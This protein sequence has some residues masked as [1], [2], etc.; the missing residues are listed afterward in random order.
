MLREIS[1]WSYPIPSLSSSVLSLSCHSSIWC[2]SF[3]FLPLVHIP[4]Y[5]V[6]LVHDSRYDSSLYEDFC[7]VV[8][9]VTHLLYKAP[10]PSFFVILNV[11][12]F[13]TQ[14]RHYYTTSEYY[15]I[16]WHSTMGIQSK[17]VLIPMLLF[18]LFQTKV[19][20]E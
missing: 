7:S 13:E 9:S 19:N 4:T 6:Q 2:H 20:L 10:D 18:L 16:K 3:L 8:Y 1:S 5:L 15:F 11:G 17:Y 12:Y 14:C